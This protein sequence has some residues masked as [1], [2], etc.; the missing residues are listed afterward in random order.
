MVSFFAELSLP[1]SKIRGTDLQLSMKMTKNSGGKVSLFFKIIHR[2]QYGI[3][4]NPA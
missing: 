1:E 4:K 3:R 2:Y